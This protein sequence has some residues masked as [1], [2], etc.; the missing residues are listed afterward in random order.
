MTGVRYLI[1]SDIHANL[2][3]LDAVLAA[4]PRATWDRVVVLGDLVGYGA[5]PN[6]VVD[7]VRALDPLAVIRGNHDKACCGIEDASNFNHVARIAASWTED[8]LTPENRSYLR[9][10]PAGPVVI[11]DRVE[12]CHGSPF[13][14]DH[15]IFDAE[16]ARR[17]LEAG[18]R[19]LCLFGHTH[20]PV[21]FRRAG[22]TFDG[23]LPEGDAD[24]TITLQDGVRYVVNPGSV[25]QPRDGDPR[26][27]FAIYDTEGPTLTLRRIPY[28]VDA[29]QRRILG[30]GLPASLANRLAVGR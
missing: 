12:I 25:G 22:N 27:G 5:D 3:A 23:F 9:D 6:A 30:A 14:E 29:A 16:D 8:H 18:D 11:D 7:R 24:T 10:L 1:L 28:A 20:L 17:A 21:V 13:D 26:A 15:Y 2:D 4:A 19:Q